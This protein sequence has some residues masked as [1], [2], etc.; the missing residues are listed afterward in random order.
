M[1]KN[2]FS[3]LNKIIIS[4]LMAMSLIGTFPIQNVSA[5]TQKVYFPKTIDFVNR[6]SLKAN[7]GRKTTDKKQY[8]II[9]KSKSWISS[10]P[11]SEYKLIYCIE[12][13]ADLHKGN[14]LTSTT[15]ASS[16]GLTEAQKTLISRIGGRSGFLQTKSGDMSWKSKV[17]YLVGQTLIWEVTEGYRNTSNF[18]YIPPKSG[19]G[20]IK[21][22]WAFKSYTDGAGVK[23]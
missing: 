15:S 17:Q 20:A 9:N 13:G 7:S 8:V 6:K 2:L 21:S 16:L 14:S 11:T 12:L 4:S 18:A 23:V 5:A 19:C 10:N 3:K 22:M 1:L